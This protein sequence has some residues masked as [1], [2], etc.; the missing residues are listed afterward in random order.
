MNKKA[1]FFTVDGLIALGIL[2]IGFV[3]IYAYFI[4]EPPEI[5]AEFFSSDLVE[6]LSKTKISDLDETIYVEIYTLVDEQYYENTLLEQT[7]FFCSHNP[8]S[9]TSLINL[10]TSEG[11]LIRPQYGFELNIKDQDGNDHCSN[12]I[13]TRG[14]IETDNPRL[15]ITAKDIIYF[16]DDDT[17]NGPYLAEVNVWQ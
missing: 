3:F 17:L 2:V 5:Q 14:D 16:I 12:P 13:Y 9:A 10:A 15:I 7:S 4:S 8:T 1:Y 6:F 11:E